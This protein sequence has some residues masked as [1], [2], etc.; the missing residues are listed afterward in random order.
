MNCRELVLAASFVAMTG[1]EAMADPPPTRVGFSSIQLRAVLGAGA[2][3]PSWGTFE[4][5][6]AAYATTQGSEIDG[7][8]T[9]FVPRLGLFV[10]YPGFGMTLY[11]SWASVDAQAQHAADSRREFNYSS[12]SIGI[13]F[14]F[15]LPLRQLPLRPGFLVGGYTG[16]AELRSGF[17]YNEQT[18]SYG[19]DQM[20]NGIF[21]VAHFGAT[22][23]IG[24]NKDVHK[25]VAVF[26]NTTYAFA[27]ASGGGQ[28]DGARLGVRDAQHENGFGATYTNYTPTVYLPTNPD[29]FYDESVYFLGNSEDIVDRD[30]GGWT[31]MLGV[32]VLVPR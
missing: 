8:G 6:R 20:L 17:R 9:N 10:G 30:V 26:F 22:F 14:E 15:L 12:R 3:I 11:G 7:F 2:W 32:Q 13:E 21:D 31:L 16:S 27:F 24:F 25:Y 23:G 5:F 18:L 29:T 28:N 4:K 19:P 1:T